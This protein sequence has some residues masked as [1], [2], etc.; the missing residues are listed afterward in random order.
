MSK[1]THQKPERAKAKTPN[2]AKPIDRP[3]KSQTA[4][5]PSLIRL[6]KFLAN[7]GVASRRKADE[8]IQN[9][10]VEVNGKLVTE[11]G[12]KIDP[13][14]DKVVANGR[15]AKLHRRK[16]YILLNKPKDAITTSRD[17][18]DRRTVLDLIGI[19][20][21]VYA[22]G[23]LDRNTTGALLLTNDGELAHRL[24]HPSFGAPKEYVAELDKKIT[25]ADLKKLK[26]G[27]R[28]SDTGEKVGACEA[29][30]LDDGYHVWLKL[31]EGKNRQVHRMFWTLGYDVKKLDRV[32][33]AGIA[34]KGLRRGEWR[35]LSP[36]EVDSLFKLVGLERETKT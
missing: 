5:A 21:R 30:I 29:A 15:V 4:S 28:L 23:R 6:N 33:Y 19:D 34:H 10:E 12:F 20:E 13:T 7:A 1:P 14:K 35:Y 9:G 18:L 25:R 8:M 26:G 36:Q 11:L 3:A 22:V 27:M 17:E 32:A 24:M 2:R 16:I 31:H